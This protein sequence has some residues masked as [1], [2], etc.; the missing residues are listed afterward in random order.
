[1]RRTV[2]WRSFVICWTRRAF[3]FW[4][5]CRPLRVFRMALIKAAK[6]DPFQP[7][8]TFLNFEAQVQAR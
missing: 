3:A 2:F 6:G 4:A 1:V 5:C 7:Y 8:C